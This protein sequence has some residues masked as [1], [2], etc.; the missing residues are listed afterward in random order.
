MNTKIIIV[1]LALLALSTSVK[2]SD[3]EQF[4]AYGKAITVMNIEKLGL[5]ADE[6][7]AFLEGV[8]A[9]LKENRLNEKD[10]EGLANLGHFLDQRQAKVNPKSCDSDQG[11]CKTC[12]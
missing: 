3:K 6:K 7:A 9:A 2:A 4:K 11:S 12:P 10:K 8:K 5:S 1:G